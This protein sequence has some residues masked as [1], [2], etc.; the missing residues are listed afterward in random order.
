MMSDVSITINQVEIDSFQRFARTATGQALDVAIE[1][2]ARQILQTVR[3]RTPVGIRYQK[4]STQARKQG[5][6]SGRWT[7]SGQLKASWTIERTGT[8]IE[9]GTPI[10]YA[11]ILE[12]GLYPGI[13]KPRMGQMPGGQGQV[14]PRTKYGPSGGIYSSRAVG[15]ILR[16]ILEDKGLMNQVSTLILEQMRAQ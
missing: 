16:P 10:D 9:I 4:A 7:A 3:Q 15:G 8:S 5:K 1:Q 11:Q 6:I 13:G 2:I 14:S 12:E